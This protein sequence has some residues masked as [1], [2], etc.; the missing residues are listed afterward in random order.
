MKGDVCQFR[1][2]IRRAFRRMGIPAAGIKGSR[3]GSFQEKHR[4]IEVRGAQGSK[5]EVVT[6][7]RI[8][9]TYRA[10]AVSKAQHLA[11]RLFNFRVS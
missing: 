7:L 8:F 11:T 5:T 6:K 1:S 9:V 3:A 4:G 10:R 2:K